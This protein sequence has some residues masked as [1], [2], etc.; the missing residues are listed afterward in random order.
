MPT[1]RLPPKN[2]YERGV[3]KNVEQFGWH[4]TSVTRGGRDDDFVP[5]SYTVGL[6]ERFGASE[7]ILF[8]L[9]GDVAHSIFSIYANRLW[10]NDPIPLDQPCSD[11]IQN[12]SCAFV[13]VPRDL[14]NEYVF[15]ALWFYAEVEFPLHQL[16]W[17]DPDGSYP[18]NPSASP[19]FL[20]QQP[21]LALRGVA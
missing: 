8:G 20:L 10:V 4:C 12:Y 1:R 18:W 11:L 14:Y 17:P 9:D 2:D 13:A 19:D 3:L 5:F 21:V 15:S 16:V 7:L 6:F